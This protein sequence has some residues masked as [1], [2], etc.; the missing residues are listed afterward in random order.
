[1][2]RKL[3]LGALATL[4]LTAILLAGCATASSDGP[5]GVAG[6][7]TSMPRDSKGSFRPDWYGQQR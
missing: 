3:V 4:T 2:S 5:S 1:M 6:E 7:K